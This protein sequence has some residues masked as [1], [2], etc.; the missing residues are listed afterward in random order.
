M[1]P[2]LRCITLALGLVSSSAFAQFQLNP[3]TLP[4]AYYFYVPS[5][6]EPSN[7]VVYTYEQGTQQFTKLAE[8]TQSGIISE[9][10]DV[11]TLENFDISYASSFNE[12]VHDLYANPQNELVVVYSLQEYFG[13][14]DAFMDHNVR[15][16][17]MVDGSFVTSLN[18]HSFAG[19]N[20]AVI[21]SERL[22]EFKQEELDLG[23]PQNIVDTYDYYVGTEGVIPYGP[24]FQWN[25][26]GTLTVS[27]ELEVFI[28]WDDGYTQDYADFI[29]TE[30]FSRTIE[31]TP[32]G[33]AQLGYEH[34]SAPATYPSI[35]TLAPSYSETG[36]TATVSGWTIYFVLFEFYYNGNY[37]SQRQPRAVRMIEGSIPKAYTRIPF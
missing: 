19:L 18:E 17:S 6:S 30:V 37:Y 26:D 11:A 1:Q 22:A 23:V 29:G 32:S 15:I 14:S 2:I 3:V 34:S 35:F 24:S 4:P 20:E 13:F 5:F 27:F 21:P 36:S 9:A 7:R 31:F 28:D 8:I 25:T 33:V 10:R 12:A 16:Y